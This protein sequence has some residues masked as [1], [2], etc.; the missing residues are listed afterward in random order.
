VTRVCQSCGA[1]VSETAKFC[2][3][4]GST[5]HSL[6]KPP[7]IEDMQVPTPTCPACSAELIEGARF[8]HMCAAE[9][10]PPPPPAT[11]DC[12]GCGQEID[13]T[14]AFCRYCGASTRDHPLPHAAPTHMTAQTRAEVTGEA[15]ERVGEPPGAAPAAAVDLPARAQAAGVKDEESVEAAAEG[16]PV[17]ALTS[18]HEPRQKAAEPAEQPPDELLMTEEAGGVVASGREEW[19]DGRARD[20]G[21]PTAHAS[22]EPEE[23]TGATPASQRDKGEDEVSEAATIAWPSAEISAS[24]DPAVEPGPSPDLEATLLLTGPAARY[25]VAPRAQESPQVTEQSPSDPVSAEEGTIISGEPQVPER[26]AA[27]QRHCAHCQAPVSETASFCRSCGGR[28]DDLDATA[29]LTAVAALV[30]AEG[31][32]LAGGRES[33]PGPASEAEIPVCPRCA[34]PVEEWAG[35]CR[36]CGAPMTARDAQA[37]STTNCEVCGAPATNNSSLCAN[38]AR[39]MGA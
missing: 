27:A 5:V 30:D 21:E 38:C 12:A 17:G 9:A 34:A 31:L 19:A 39:A 14:D 26:P 4:C 16:A 15:P 33:G 32:T 29:K 2:R 8:C 36:H 7:P 37:V 28:L 11:I 6:V 23:P 35:F 24:A 10:P 3:G 22:P 1:E 25:R 20:P 13:G 18:E